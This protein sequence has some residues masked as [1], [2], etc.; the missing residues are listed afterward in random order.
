MEQSLYE[1]VQPWKKK[2]CSSA[3]AGQMEVLHTIEFPG[4]SHAFEGLHC[5]SSVGVR[6]FYRRPHDLSQHKLYESFR[7]PVLVRYPL[8]SKEVQ[9]SQWTV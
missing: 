6:I 1:R 8:Q 4:I 3:A 5:R 9:K 7:P 2:L